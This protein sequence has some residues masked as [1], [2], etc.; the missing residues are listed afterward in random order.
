[1]NNDQISQSRLIEIVVLDRANLSFFFDSSNGSCLNTS[2][3][4]AASK[5][6]LNEDSYRS[7]FSGKTTFEQEVAAGN[8]KISGDSGMLR[9]FGNALRRSQ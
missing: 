1:M 2:K 5:I 8:L 4:K 9:A 6:T 7:L 3:D